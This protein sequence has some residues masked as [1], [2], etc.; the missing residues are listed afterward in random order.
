M[1]ILKEYTDSTLETDSQEINIYKLC[2]EN[3]WRISVTI[4]KLARKYRPALASGREVYNAESGQL[5]EIHGIMNNKSVSLTHPREISEEQRKKLR[6][7]MHEIHKKQRAA[8]NNVK[9]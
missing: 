9:N 7:H 8:T 1:T 2:T 3:F 6:A 5:V 4:P